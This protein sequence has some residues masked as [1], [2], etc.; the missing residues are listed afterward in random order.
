MK[1]RPRINEPVTVRG[2]TY[3]DP[4]ACAEA[5]GV[6]RS[7][8]LD[9]RRD[10]W[11]DNLGSQ[12]AKQ[13]RMAALCPFTVRGQEFATFQACAE[14]FGISEKAVKN[15][16]T[17]GRADMIG[18]PAHKT[19]KR[20]GVE[21]MAVRIRGKVFPTAEAAAKHFKVSVET[22]RGAIFK[23]REDFVGLGRKRKHVKPHG[24][25]P[26]NAKPIQIGAYSWTS[27]RLCA[28]DLG[29]KVT[30][31]KEHVR[32]DD[33]EWLASKLFDYIARKEGKR[34]AIPRTMSEDE[35]RHQSELMTAS[36]QARKTLQIAAE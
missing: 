31:L 1:P 23:G 26:H 21:P 34:G 25:V 16:V 35:Q 18:L 10:G 33:K 28:T 8:V 22:I 24:G 27:L 20:H 2:I 4:D 6:S 15:A 5:L 14:A 12:V 7:A 36:W 13:Q 17:K 30:N 11:L 29:V 19:R 3:P 32:R 9:A